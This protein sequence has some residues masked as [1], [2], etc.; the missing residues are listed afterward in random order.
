MEIY[1]ELELSEVGWF[2]NQTR[3]RQLCSPPSHDVA[4]GMVL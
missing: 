1:L 4:V 3:R 2:S